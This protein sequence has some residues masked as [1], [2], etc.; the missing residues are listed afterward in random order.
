MG[1]P[2][3]GGRFPLGQVSGQRKAFAV[4][5]YECEV[6]LYRAVYVSLPLCSSKFVRRIIIIWMIKLQVVF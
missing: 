6:L 4:S 3:L 2:V 1:H 5:V